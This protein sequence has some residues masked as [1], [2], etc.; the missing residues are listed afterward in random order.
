MGKQTGERAN[1]RGANTQRVPELWRSELPP[2]R[3]LA[4]S[5]LMSRPITKLAQALELSDDARVITL[6]RAPYRIVHTNKSEPPAPAGPSPA[7][8]S[9]ACAHGLLT[10]PFASAAQN[11][12]LAS[13]TLT[14]R[15]SARVA[16]QNGVK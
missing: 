15:C 2:S 13:H 14:R 7:A 16:S 8:H 6:G 4:P 11:K 3:V 1:G 5:T 10:L 12:L 9:A